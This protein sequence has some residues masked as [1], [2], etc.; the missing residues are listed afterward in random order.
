MLPSCLAVALQRAAG[1]NSL[2]KHGFFIR[3]VIRMENLTLGR[4]SPALGTK[5]QLQ[6]GGRARALGS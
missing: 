4:G 5:Q 3:K 2:L 6:V 1:G